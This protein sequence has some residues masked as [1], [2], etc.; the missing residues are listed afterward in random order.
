M[1]PYEW[2]ASLPCFRFEPYAVSPREGSLQLDLGQLTH[3]A[4][5]YDQT[6]DVVSVEV[7]LIGSLETTFRNFYKTTLAMGTQSFTVPIW[8]KSAFETREAWFVGPPPVFTPVADGVV[9]TSFSLVT[10]EVIAEY[11][12]PPPEYDPTVLARLPWGYWP[13]RDASP[14]TSFTD[15]TGNGRELVYTG[16]GIVY[17]Q[18]PLNT[19]SI[20]DSIGRDDDTSSFRLQVDADD[21][22]DNGV[23]V[24]VGGWVK[25]YNDSPTS[26]K[27][28]FHIGG[29]GGSGQ[30]YYV[31][32]YRDASG[33]VAMAWHH[34]TG[35]GQNFVTKTFT[36]TLPLDTIFWFEAG[37]DHSNSRVFFRMNDG[38]FEYVAFDG[39]DSPNGLDHTAGRV[40]RFYV[41]H[42]PVGT[43]SDPI[44]G[45]FS[46]FEAYNSVV[47]LDMWTDWHF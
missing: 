29:G 23:S 7:V 9:K 25:F 1:T 12:P 47:T 28:L 36:T 27:T 31:W 35:P 19:D 32:C 30:F 3:R 4:R 14:T 26:E 18:G 44:D 8:I 13:F 22:Y 40:T 38:A 46:N 37:I 11:V 20:A 33:N 41:G 5:V 2:P 45:L 17:Q 16:S 42:R 39:T 6:G 21:I 24:T 10:R 15:L 34:D 43:V